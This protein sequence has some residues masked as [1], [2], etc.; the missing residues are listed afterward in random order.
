MD[1]TLTE[2]QE[3]IQGAAREFL[4]ARNTAAGT[5]AMEDD[6]AGWSASLW[7]QMVEL[8][9]LGL[10][11][12]EEHGGLDASFVEVCLLAEEMGRFQVPSPYLPTVA[13]CALP[14]ARFG[15]DDQR[16]RWLEAIA[17]GRVM[18]YVRGAPRGQWASTGADIVASERDD[19][20]VLAGTALFVPYARDAE[21]MVVAARR[22]GGGP[23]DLVAFLVDTA[24]A[25]IT[26]EP[27]QVVGGDRLYRVVFDDVAVDSVLGGVAAGPAVVELASAYG[28]AA[29]CAEMVGGAQRV[30]DMTVEYARGREQFGR[31]VGSFQAVQH[32]CA[33][34]AIDVLSSRFAAYE[35]IWRLSESLDAA[36]EVSM[37]KAWVSE[38]YQRV[39]ALGHQVH[40]AIGFTRE[41]DLHVYSRHAMAA[42][43]TFGD[44]EHHWDQVA[45]RLGLPAT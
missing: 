8:G 40:G 9:W 21:G 23:A 3:L 32:H 5:R 41:H 27:L 20:F 13:C 7:K 44:G 30:L 45:Q 15:D 31:P 25:G 10:A 37:A 24:A 11:L 19:G 22:A 35:A 39:C 18:T 38:A 36:M 1:L 16:A 17:R 29:T 42:A 26:C 34:I 4:E 2:D 43:L 12:P 28:T 33:D 6:P 14:I